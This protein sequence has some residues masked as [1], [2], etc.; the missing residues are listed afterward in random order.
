MKPTLARM[1][2]YF[3]VMV[4]LVAGLAGCERRA[5]EREVEATDAV[6][7]PQATQRASEQQTA[8]AG[9]TVVSAVTAPLRGTGTV[10]A[11]TQPPAAETS[12]PTIAEATP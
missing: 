12:T 4:L 7:T 11:V 2:L 10:V 9:E 1:A 3:L 8:Q 5:E 6:T